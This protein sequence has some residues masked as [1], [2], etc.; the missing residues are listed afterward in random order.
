[1]AELPRGIRNNNPG[2][3]RKGERWQGAAGDDGAFVKFSSMA[4]GLRALMRLVDTHIGRGHNTTR[5]LISVWAP[6]MENQTAIYIAYVAK[7]LGYGPDAVLPKSK[8]LLFR[9]ASAISRKE[10]GAQY[11]PKAADL[12]AA[13]QLLPPSVQA[14]YK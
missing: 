7:L 11:A 6:P 8:Q 9:L 14:Q 2:N 4:F 5:K 3:I 13:Y 12:E 10:N 1:M